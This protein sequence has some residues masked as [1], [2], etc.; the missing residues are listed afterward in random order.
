[1]ATIRIRVSP[2]GPFEEFEIPDAPRVPRDDLVTLALPSG[3]IVSGPPEPEQPIQDGPDFDAE[4]L[5][6]EPNLMYSGSVDFDYV[7]YGGDD[8]ETVTLGLYLQV[9]VDGG[10]TW[11]TVANS[12]RPIYSSGVDSQQSGHCQMTLP[13]TLG[14][15]LGVTDETASIRLRPAVNRSAFTGSATLTVISPQGSTPPI[16]N[17]PGTLALRLHESPVIVA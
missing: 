9:S 4:L 6:P 17:G 10:A 5:E 3:F 14:S 15:V 8:N 13:P 2:S 12:S 16:P 11:N 7:Y 1:M